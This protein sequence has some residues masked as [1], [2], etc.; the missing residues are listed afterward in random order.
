MM[1]TLV[2]T[3]AVCLFLVLWSEP[4][5]YLGSRSRHGDIVTVCDRSSIPEPDLTPG[6]DI[7]AEVQGWREERPTA[8]LP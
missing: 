4:G 7:D 3:G 2:A 5:A 1:H 8:M 6:V